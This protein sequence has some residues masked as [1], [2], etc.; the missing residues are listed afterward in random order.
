MTALTAPALVRCEVCNAAAYGV[1][2]Y[3]W[4]RPDCPNVRFGRRFG[5]TAT[6][7]LVQERHALLLAAV[8][9]RWWAPWRGIFR[10]HRLAVVEAKLDARGASW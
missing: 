10:R 8:D 7:R 9:D 5:K 1:G 6:A 2:C 3:D 4:P